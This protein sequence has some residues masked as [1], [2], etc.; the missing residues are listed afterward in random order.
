MTEKGGPCKEHGF[1][2]WGICHFLWE[3]G[4]VSCSGQVDT[5]PCLAGL[6]GRQRCLTSLGWSL[7]GHRGVPK[8]RMQR[9]TSQPVFRT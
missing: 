4:P 3:T 7:T 6:L 1:E 5:H 9:E 8:N 2:A